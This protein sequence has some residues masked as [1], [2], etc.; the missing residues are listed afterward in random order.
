VKSEAFSIDEAARG[1][2]PYCGHES[3]NNNCQCCVWAYEMRRRG[4]DVIAK[5]Q[6]KKYDQ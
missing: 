3:H 4:F 1:A 5:P 2:N 6:Q